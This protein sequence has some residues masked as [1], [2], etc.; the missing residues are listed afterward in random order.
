MVRTTFLCGVLATA[1]SYTPGLYGLNAAAALFQID[2]NGTYRM[3]SPP[4]PY[5][6]AQQLSTVDGPRGI[7]YFVGY[8]RASAQPCLV[9]L[10]LLNGS[11]LSETP[12]PEFYDR[13]Y[14]GIGQYV[15][16]DPASTRVFVGGQD[17]N[18]FH[19]VGLVTPAT[20]SFT[21]LANL[22][23][24]LRDVFGGTSVFVPE[25]NE[26]WFEL[27]LDIMILSLSTR[28]VTVLPVSET[29]EILGMNLDPH[30]GDTVFGLGGGP[31][32]SVRSVVALHARNRSIST[33]G[34]IP[35]YGQ[36][37][38][39]ITAYDYNEKTIFWIAQTSGADPSSPWFLVQNAVEGGKT[40][41]AVQICGNA[42][43]CPWSLH[44]AAP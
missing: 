35:A 21:L 40:M 36:Q 12:L 32:Q 15:A 29:F 43:L 7:F 22:S 6:E 1:A 5:V 37:M 24:S 9:G 13:N 38:G 2:A 26:L 42:E 8:S 10:S 3:L 31:G 30:D 4:L 34:T 19:V 44:F 27:D 18:G 14:V 25:T 41:S 11:T 39:G 28:N 20:G 23:S 17:V 33:V 16:I